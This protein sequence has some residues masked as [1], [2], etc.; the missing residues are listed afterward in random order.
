MSLS[1][2]SSRVAFV[3]LAAVF[4]LALNL[5]GAVAQDA[6]LETRLE[7]RHDEY[8]RAATVG[9][10][11]AFLG[12]FSEDAVVMPVTG[13]TFEG[14]E[15]IRRYFNEAGQFESLEI[16]STRA[17]RMGDVIVDIGTFEG[18]FKGEDVRGEYVTLAHDE[19]GKIMIDRLVSFMPREMKQ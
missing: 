16:E 3:P 17:E 11:D 12:M 4:A 6:E 10:A 2:I 5:G 1:G 19:D 8:I 7:Q 18:S 13:G 9:D 15:E 14:T